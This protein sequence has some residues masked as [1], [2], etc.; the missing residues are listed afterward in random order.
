[1]SSPDEKSNQ[2]VCFGGNAIWVG[3]LFGRNVF[4]VYGVEQLHGVEVAQHAF[5]HAPGVLH[6]MHHSGGAVCDVAS[7]KQPFWGGHF[8]RAGGRYYTGYFPSLLLVSRRVCKGGG[9]GR[10]GGRTCRGSMTG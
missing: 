5:G 10:E 2:N 8:V 1:M 9:A 3:V 4:F 6:G 7:G